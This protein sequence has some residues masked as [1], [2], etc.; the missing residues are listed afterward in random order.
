MTFREL[1]P[2]LTHPIANDDSLF[3]QLALIDLELINSLTEET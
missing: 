2:R 1:S 3:S